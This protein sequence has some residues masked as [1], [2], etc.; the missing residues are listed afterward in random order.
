MVFMSNR[1]ILAATM[2]L[3]PV[4]AH[5]HHAMDGR[6]P[7]TFAEGLLSGLGHPVIGLDHLAA[8]AAIGL[9]ASLSPHRVK[10]IAAFFVSMVCGVGLHVARLDLPL[11]EAG[12]ALSLV[13]F[14]WLLIRASVTPAV[15]AALVAAAAGALHGYAYGESIVGAEA[16]PLGAYLLGLLVVQAAIALGVGSGARV[17]YRA[18]PVRGERISLASGALVVVLGIALLRL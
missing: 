15:P 10:L 11:S 5:A 18:F 7:A 8:V 12:I 14:G 4:A 1:R 2:L 17:V 9:I 6:T 13:A 3:S 16:T